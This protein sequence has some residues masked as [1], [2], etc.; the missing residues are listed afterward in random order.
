V[1]GV[2]AATFA[3]VTVG[4]TQASAATTNTLL[5]STD[6]GATWSPNVTAAAGSTVLVREWYDNS[7]PAAHSSESLTTG[8]PAGFSLVPGS[9]KVCTSPATTNPSAPN[10]SQDTCAASNESAV[11]S[12]QNLTVS[13]TNGLYGQPNNLTSGILNLG[14]KRDLNLN[15]CVYYN[16]TSLYTNTV[17]DNPTPLYRTGTNASNTPQ[18]TVNCGPGAPPGWVL[19]PNDTAV[20]AIDLLGNR[21]LNLNQCVY[22]NGTALYTNTVNDNPTPLYRTGTNASNT[23]QSTVNCGP[24]APPGWVLYPNDTAVQAIDLLDTARGAGFVQF[25]ITAPSPASTTTYNESAALTGAA[26]ANSSGS[27]TIQIVNASL[28]NGGSIGATTALAVVMLAGLIGY[29]RLRVN[30]PTAR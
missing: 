27:I 18:S 29:R 15:Q 2:A 8:V 1:L 25:A 30:T 12:G 7:D 20:Q 9:T 4:A 19:Y 13:P 5:Y 10:S 21:Y 26:T 6:S 23:P 11:W 14:Q 24:G 16:G 3:L 22:Y 17:N 28:I